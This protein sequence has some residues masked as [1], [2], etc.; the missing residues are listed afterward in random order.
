M[1]TR[2]SKTKMLISYAHKDEPYF[3]VFNEG[4]KVLAKN[5]TKYDWNIWE[6]TQLHVGTFWDK[7]IREQLAICDVAV[8]L[9]SENF[10]ASN[11]VMDVEF[12]TFLE[13][14]YEKGLQLIP[15][16][17]G[18]CNFSKIEEL[19]IRQFY[20]P[21]GNEYGEPQ[22]PEFTYADLVR[23]NQKDGMLIPNPNIER[24]HLNFFERVEKSVREFIESKQVLIPEKP[25][26]IDAPVNKLSNYPKPKPYFTGRENELKEFKKAID[27]KATFIAIDGSGGIGKTQFVSRC[28]ELYIPAERII[29]YD[30]TPASQ[31]D[32]LISE[33]G[34]PDLLKGSSKTDREKFS[35]FKDKIQNNNFFLFLN[36]FHETNGNYIFKEFLKFIQEY[37]HK[38]CVIVIDRDDIGDAFLTPVPIHIKGFKE[39]KLKYAKALIA[40]SYRNEIQ[41]SDFELEKLCE[42]LKGYP[43]AIDFAMYLLSEGESSSD[44]I[45]KIVKDA[46]AE[47]ISSRLLNAIF[48]RP[49]ASK[50]ERE[51]ICQFSVFSGIV[52]EEAIKTII[53]PPLLSAMRSLRKKN[54]IS[55]F[56]G[57]YE[58]HPLVREFCYKELKD[59]VSAHSKVAEYYIG[60]RMSGKLNSALEEQIFYHLAK[61]EQW[62]RI[63]TEIEK[64]GRN[65]IR[66]GQLSLVKELLDKLK[67]IKIERPIFNIFYGDLDE[68]QGRWD[69][70]KENFN[71]AQLQDIDKRVK[72]EGMIKYGEM[73]YRKG[74]VKESLSLFE[75]AR[76]FSKENNFLKEEARALNDI[77]LVY[78]SFGD[79]A[80]S[81]E[82]INEALVIRENIGDKLEIAT[83]VGS[84]GSVFFSQ[85]IL[86]RALEKF[87]ISLAIM[88]EIGDKSGIANAHNDIGLVLR[89]KR[90]LIGSMEKFQVA[91]K[92]YEEIG[93]K[94]GIGTMMNNIGL[95]LSDEDKLKEAR[96]KFDLSFK[97]SKEVGDKHGIGTS[98][99]NI[100]ALLNQQEQFEESLEIY[101]QSLV[102]HEQLKSK[103]GIASNLSEM[104]YVY[105]NKKVKKYDMAL[106]CLLKSLGMQNQMGVKNPYVISVIYRIRDKD[107][108]L[109]SF[110]KLIKESY[111]KLSDDLKFHVPLAD[112][113]KEPFTGKKKE[114]RNDPCSCGSGRKYKSCHGK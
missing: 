2:S 15:I 97:I 21:K 33:A 31:L 44:I 8:L 93:N 102:V 59:K 79:F 46:D 71:Q 103:L 101:E 58:I 41:I 61:S 76:K 85:N 96:D 68:I 108:G 98:L 52:P 28:I 18:P 65:F 49:D 42:Q 4:M 104:G 88:E 75:V 77:G 55:H 48:N 51:L 17:F 63:E 50:E 87:R 84:I 36:N 32:T 107:I 80:I 3:K 53:L 111:G 39:D 38:G 43:L 6:D 37:L 83:S 13:R 47:Q 16:V 105:A 94:S 7:E 72:G 92:V 14:H 10:M 1:T 25:I 30:C 56:N 54:L 5:S 91:L 29:Y 114:G 106:L 64:N 74:D 34:F 73:F 69:S 89:R 26:I 45:T 35:A 22:I 110:K 66:Q 12:K 24:Y 82:K 81:L 86:D 78:N 95:V 19:N 70:A 11:Y 40:H 57:S 112:L 100:A 113:M 20:K 27:S 90:K 67:K 23:H 9:V 109:A 62:K 60:K 99:H